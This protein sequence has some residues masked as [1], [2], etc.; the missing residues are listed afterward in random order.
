MRSRVFLW[1]CL[2]IPINI[3]FV[4][5]GEVF[6][7][8]LHSTAVTLFYNAVVT[9]FFLLLVN[10]FFFKITPQLTLTRSEILTLYVMVSVS[11]C[12]CGHDMMQILMTL[13]GH[14]HWFSNEQNQWAKRLI[15]Y[16]PGWLIVDNKEAL[17]GYYNGGISVGQNLGAFLRPMM[18]WWLFTM[19]LFWSLYHLVSIFKDGWIYQ[20]RL[21]FP[22]A[23]IPLEITGEE[24]K[25]F[26]NRL[27]WM[28]FGVAGSLDILHG[29]HYLFPYLPDLPT[30]WDLSP[31]IVSLSPPWNAIGWTPL[32][33]YPFAIG[34]SYFIP[35]DLAFSCWFFYYFWKL[36]MVIRSAIGIPPMPGPYQS[37]QSSGAWIGIGLIVLWMGRKYIRQLFSRKQFGHFAGL[38]AGFAGLIVFLR[39]AGMSL[40]VAFSFFVIYFII[41][42]AIARMRAE[43][44]PPTH[45]LYFAG[46]E[47]IIS[48]FAG[49]KVLGAHNLAMFSLLYWL[50]RDYRCH[51][52]GHM[53]EGMKIASQEREM[54][55]SPLIFPILFAGA[56][57]FVSAFVIFLHIFDTWGLGSRL[58][59]YYGVHIAEESFNRLDRWLSQ[60]TSP[61]FLSIRHF[62]YGLA[63][64]VV[65]NGFKK[66]FPFHPFHPVGYAV[67]GSWTMS[68]LWF[69]VFL[70][71]LIKIFLLKYGGLKS[72]TKGMPFFLG[73][74]LG[75]YVIG[76]MWV[77]FGIITK[78][79]IY[80]FFI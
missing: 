45:D 32:C 65:L 77:L 37:A 72:Y 1:A 70:S 76:A 43:L 57:G 71:W 58:G 20:E 22:V 30:R 38:F 3:Y 14:P 11:T 62:L 40:W 9:L 39:I 74:I 5:M 44:G 46:P 51:P 52:V 25:L 47:W 19:L 48:I 66:V 42:L 63:L 10:R 36:Q 50:T 13:I 68:H 78:L 53:I 21:A 60:P 7:Y 34:L 33:V 17:S 12:L 59:N 18:F 56:L 8:P 15:P 64:V 55:K 27:F 26:I 31:Y 35:T 2:L 61:D 29:L 79:E 67:A 54:A 4:S 6:F 49:T 16:L 69:S 80:R 28:G 41:C 75:E 23:Q 24:S 73:L